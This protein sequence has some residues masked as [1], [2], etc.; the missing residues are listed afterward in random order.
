VEDTDQT[1]RSHPYEAIVISFGVG[2]V[3]GA[4]IG[5]LRR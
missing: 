3:A 4:L 1:I 5:A 2:L